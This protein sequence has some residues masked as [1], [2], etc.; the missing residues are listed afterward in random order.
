MCPTVGV[1]GWRVQAQERCKG[2]AVMRMQF[3]MMWFRVLQGDW[4][5]WKSQEICSGCSLL[6]AQHQ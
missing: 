3:V 1:L 4:G 2:Q 5:G 6:M